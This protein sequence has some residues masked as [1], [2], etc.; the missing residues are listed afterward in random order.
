MNM[1]AFWQVENVSCVQDR[2]CRRGAPYQLIVTLQLKV[3]KGR[4]SVAGARAD[5]GTVL[6][7]C[8]YQIGNRSRTRF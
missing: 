2:I 1:K 8:G 5:E 4:I 3:G 6:A 7:G